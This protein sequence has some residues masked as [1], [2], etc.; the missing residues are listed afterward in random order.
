MQRKARQGKSRQG[1]AM[2]LK[3]EQGK[4]SEINQGNLTVRSTL[5]LADSVP[6]V[7][8]APRYS[9]GNEGT[10][11]AVEH[12]QSIKSNPIQLK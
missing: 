7:F 11:K 2:Q 8:Y 9:W 12:S 1:K 6:R 5:I 4:A 3:A 10:L